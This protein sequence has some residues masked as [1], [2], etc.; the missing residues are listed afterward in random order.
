MSPKIL[1]TLSA[2]VRCGYPNIRQTTVFVQI[3]HDL[4]GHGFPSVAPAAIG[5]VH[6]I[7]LRL[8]VHHC[9]NSQFMLHLYSHMFHLSRAAAEPNAW[10][11]PGGNKHKCIDNLKIHYYYMLNILVLRSSC[12][13]K[14][15]R[16]RLLASAIG[17]STAF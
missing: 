1:L 14:V 5:V 8:K 15:G 2:H 16:R 10:Q 17:R 12:G 3:H 4:R 6:H 9:S 7:P 13:G 11:H